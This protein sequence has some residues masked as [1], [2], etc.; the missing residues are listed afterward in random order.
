MKINAKESNK[1]KNWIGALN[2]KDS[3]CVLI[4]ADPDALGAAMALRRLLSKHSVSV[5]IMRIN[6]ISRPDNLAMIRYLHIPVK[7]W[8]PSFINNYDKFAIVDSQQSHNVAFGDITFSVVV[9]H[10]PVPEDKPVTA[11]YMD[12]RPDFG[13]TCTI[14]A[15]YLKVMKIVPSRSLATAMLFGIRTDTAAFERSGMELDLQAY[16]WL[17]KHADTQLLRRI[18]RSEYLI[19]WMPWFG[20]AFKNLKK[21]CPGG[22][23]AHV[24]E[25]G[26]TDILVAIADFFTKVHG[27]KWVV[28]SGVYNKTVIVV[29]RGDGSI[30]LGK[31][32]MLAFKDLGTAGGHKVMARAEFPLKMV[33][34]KN[35]AA[36]I[37]ESVNCKIMLDKENN[38]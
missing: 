33:G 5:D 18:L 38:R 28:I 37:A 26:T 13:A 21:C 10:H 23:H 12:I 4:N 20:R 1:I 22:A 3:W 11:E 31:K 16:Q 19:E 27:L 29:F 17:S 6:E 25:V 24:G 8:K 14:F 7:I 35:V 32:A 9:D 34:G 15:R 2:K 30:D 36:F